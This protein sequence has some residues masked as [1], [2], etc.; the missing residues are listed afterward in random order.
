MPKPPPTTRRPR[1]LTLLILLA[2]PAVVAACGGGAQVGDAHPNILLVITDDQPKRT[3]GP[4]GDTRRL[5]GRGGTYFSDAFVT[6]PECCPSRSS[7]YSGRYAHDAGVQT[8]T[9]GAEFDA[10]MSWERYLQEA[11]YQTALFGKYLNGW[12]ET[13][14]PPPYFNRYEG[15]FQDP[16]SGGLRESDYF[17]LNQARIFLDDAESDDDQPWALVVA[18]HSPHAPFLPAKRY[19]DADVSRFQSTNPAMSERDLSD[20]APA[21]VA[22]QSDENGL[23]VQRQQLRMLLATDD[24]IEGIFNRLEDAGEAQDTLSFFIS[25]NGYHWGE[26]GLRSKAHPYLPDVSVPLYVR[27]PGHVKPG[28]VDDRIAANIDIAPTIFDAAQ[29]RADYPVDGR[30][31]LSSDRRPWLLLEGPVDSARFPRWNAHIDHAREYVEWDDGFKEYYDLERDPWQLESLLARGDGATDAS[32]DRLS[33]Q[34]RRA[35]TC[36]GADCP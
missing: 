3:M 20:K 22:N 21:V 8:N 2:V 27:W 14:E 19:E 30:S 35:E 17:L 12:D 29:I 13:G 7:I 1:A 28:A 5:Y 26:H 10:E 31:L 6:T 4:M 15:R 33:A 16:D 18:F 32:I 34:L 11:G 25:D 23:S 9:S 24:A 36:A